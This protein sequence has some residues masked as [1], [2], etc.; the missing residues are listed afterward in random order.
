LTADPGQR[1]KQIRERVNMTIRDVEDASRVIADRHD[2]D[3][4][5][6]GLSRLSDIENKGIIPTI[7][8]LYSLCVIFR[9]DPE[10]VLEWYGVDMASI[11]ADSLAIE[12]SGTHPIGFSANGRGEVL[13]PL[14]LDPGIDIRKTT[15]LSRMIQRWGRLPLAL[16]SGLD[17]KGRRYAFIGMDDYRMHPQLQPGSL[18]QIDESRRKIV[19]TGWSTEWERPI[20]F[21]EHRGGYVCCWCTLNEHQLVLQPHPASSCIPEVFK[22]PDDIEVIGQVTG[23]AMRLD[24]AG[25]RRARS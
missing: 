23:V 25:R 20:Y 5:L 16:F 13:I 17:P 10:E 12:L 19:N 7:Y 8:R 15:Y 14:S 24:L 1:L 2:N 11:A 3:E 4:Y 9:L 21:F 22:Y 6:I 18:V